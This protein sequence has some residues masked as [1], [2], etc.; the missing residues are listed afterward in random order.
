[1]GRGAGSPLA[2]S[3]REGHPAV[4]WPRRADQAGPIEA[5]QQPPDATEVALMSRGFLG[6]MAPDGGLTE[7]PCLLREAILPARTGF[8]CDP[9][10]PLDRTPSPGGGPGAPQRNGAN[11]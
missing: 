1:M 10:D 3:V 5:D 6:I 11:V 9:G 4:K 8:P 2:E 7:L